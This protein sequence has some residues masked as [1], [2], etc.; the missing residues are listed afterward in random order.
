MKHALLC[1][2]VDLANARA[3]THA[4]SR[5]AHV[6]L[7]KE[8]L[9]DS[10]LAA[11]FTIP[12]ILASRGIYL[13]AHTWE[14]TRGPSSSHCSLSFSVFEKNEQKTCLSVQKFLCFL[15]AV[16]ALGPSGDLPEPFW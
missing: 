15:P 1:K 13:V 8:L 11:E 6:T 3:C 9:T 14:R 5:P 12:G 10:G 4:L 7:L 16:A 2:S